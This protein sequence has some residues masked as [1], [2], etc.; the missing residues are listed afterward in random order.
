VSEWLWKTVVAGV[1]FGLVLAV[2]GAGI[3]LPIW[4]GAVGVDV[5]ASIPFVTVPSLLWHTLYGVVLG[6]GF[7]VGDGG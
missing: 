2:A 6:V 5:G 1:V 4:L 3:V 7:H